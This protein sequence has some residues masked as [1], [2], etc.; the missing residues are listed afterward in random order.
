MRPINLLKLEAIIFD[1]KM[2]GA[3]D[4]GDEAD[5][6]SEICLPSGKAFRKYEFPNAIEESILTQLDFG[7]LCVS[8]R[9]SKWYH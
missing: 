2:Y 6:K 7:D 3:G 1:F 5:N 9:K 4:S 8:R